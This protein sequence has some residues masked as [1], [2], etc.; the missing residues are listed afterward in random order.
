M[1]HQQSQKMSEPEFTATWSRMT[2][3]PISGT[4]CLITDGEV[5]VIATYLKDAVTGEAIWLF[6]RLNESEYKPFD[7]QGWTYLPRIPENL[8][9]TEKME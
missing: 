2:T 4:R 9:S 6:E 1:L 7:V 5:V 3:P 8:N